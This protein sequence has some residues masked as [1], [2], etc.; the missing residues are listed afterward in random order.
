M[1]TANRHPME[2]ILRDQDERFGDSFQ[3]AIYVGASGNKSLV[4]R[5]GQAT[6]DPVAYPT[7]SG[8]AASMTPGDEVLMVRVGKGYVVLGKI[9]R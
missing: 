5:D 8:A 4:R 1:N 6:G 9:L 3:R 7:I 2:R